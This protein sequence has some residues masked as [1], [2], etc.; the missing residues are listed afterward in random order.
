MK[1]LHLEPIGGVAGDMVLSLMVDLG[2]PP[3]MLSE[4]LSDFL[5]KKIKVEFEETSSGFLK[6]KKLK[7]KKEFQNKIIEKKQDLKK[8]D[9][10]KVN[11]NLKFEIKKIFLELFLMEEKIHRERNVKLHEIGSLDTLLD[12]L[13]F[14]MAKEFLKISSF[15]V[16]PIPL[17]SG[18]VKTSHGL[19]SVPAPL[20]K[21]FLKDF[22][23]IPQ[24]G[25]GET[26]TPT[27]ALILKN[28]FTSAPEAPPIYLEKIGFGFGNKEIKE[29]PNVLKG[30]LGKIE[31]KKEEIFE[32]KFNL[33]DYTGQMSG[34]LMD[35]LFK[36]GAKEVLIYPVT[37]KKSRPGIVFEV[38][39]YEKDFV[40]IKELI[41]KESTTLGIRYR[42]MERKTL[43]R[44]F[45][46]VDTPFGKIPL[47]LGKLDGKVVQA[48]F[49]YEDLKKISEKMK[50]PLKEIYL[51]LNPII[52]KFYEELHLL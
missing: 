38:L 52:L 20:T 7:E 43:E 47:K 8:L 9:K 13:G 36:N 26:V 51:K 23:S 24:K 15:S 4:I 2:F 29:Y 18:F 5:N 34:N 50:I 22:L 31:E 16:G 44:E 42:K 33:D 25:I 41:F 11:K 3:K 27:G 21:I 10:L 30:Y 6:G 32:I 14:L 49:E 39:C 46:K 45:L 35:L 28:F 48:S 37:M 40:N 19:I 17:G 12:L 1:H